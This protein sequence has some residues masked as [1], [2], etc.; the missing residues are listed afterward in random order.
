MWEKPKDYVLI[1]SHI[2]IILSSASRPDTSLSKS[3]QP[4][5]LSQLQSG[6]EEEEEEEEDSSEGSVLSSESSLSSKLSS[7]RGFSPDGES[8]SPQSMD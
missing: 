8:V 5:T 3:D 1:P 7:E 2:I 6:E 4:R